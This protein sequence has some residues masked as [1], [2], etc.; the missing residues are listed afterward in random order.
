MRKAQAWPRPKCTCPCGSSCSRRP[1]S[2][3]RRGSREAERFDQTAPLTVLINPVIEVVD[4]A[5]EGGWEGCLSVPGLRGWVERARHIRYTGY[6]T[7]GRRI[8]RVAKGF[9][10]RVVQH[11]CDHLDGV[12]YPQRMHDLKKLLFESEIQHWLE[13]RE[14]EERTRLNEHAGARRD[15][16]ARAGGDPN[17]GFSDAALEGGR[18][19]SRRQCSGAEGGI[20]ERRRE[21]WSKPS[22]IGP[23]THGRAHAA[24]SRRSASRD[25]VTPCGE[26][27]ASKRSRRTRKRRA[28]RPRFLRCRRMRR[29]RPG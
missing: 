21:R 2:A 26:G 23:M 10:A 28:A 17:M 25:R 5:P 19:K 29:S 6:D 15:S 4:P 9:H 27:A 24:K 12:L 20:P 22:R 13:K 11:E 16:A 1:A 7:D 18:G 3:A 14:V 8:V